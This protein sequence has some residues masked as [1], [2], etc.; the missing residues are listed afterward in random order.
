MNYCL[1]I[2]LLFARFA[3]A[4]NQVEMNVNEIFIRYTRTS[5][6]FDSK[7]FGPNFWLDV[8]ALIPLHIAYAAQA[9]LLVCQIVSLPRLMRIQVSGCDFLAFATD[10]PLVDRDAP[11]MFVAPVCMVRCNATGRSHVRT[12]GGIV[13]GAPCFVVK[14]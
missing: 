7:H 2:L 13:Q 10:A 1:D 6:Y 4:K 11:C 12:K 3:D 14:T 8:L 9:P 5:D